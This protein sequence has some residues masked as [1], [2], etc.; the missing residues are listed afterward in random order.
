MTVTTNALTDAER[1][2][3]IAYHRIFSQGGQAEGLA[4]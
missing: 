2:H 3:V 4:P 1:W